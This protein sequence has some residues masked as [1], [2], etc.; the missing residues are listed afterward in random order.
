MSETK[1]KIKTKLRRGDMV[2]IISGKENGKEGKILV[3]DREKGKVVV[4]GRNIQTKHVKANQQNRQ[5]GIIKKEAPIDISN[6][7]LLHKGKPTRIGYQV[8]VKEDKEDDKIVRIVTK[9]RI[10]KS[11]GDVI[12]ST[13][14]RKVL[15][16]KRG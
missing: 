4:E 3:V 6:V 16:N 2:E 5:G 8:E 9:K 11:T 14:I 7:L 1:T 12:D 10:A 15:K 13:T